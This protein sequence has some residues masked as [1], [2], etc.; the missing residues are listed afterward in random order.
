MILPLRV[1]GTL[2]RN[3]IS[4]GATAGPE[5]RARMAEQFFAQRF[6]RFITLFERDKRFDHFADQRDRACR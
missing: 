1:F 3:S 2:S 5:S 4:R 6:A